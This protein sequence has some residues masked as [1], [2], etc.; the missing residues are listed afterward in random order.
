MNKIINILKKKSIPLD[1]F[2]DISL[3]DKKSGYYMKKNPFGKNGDYITSPLVSNLFGEMIAIWC[4]SFWEYLGKPKKFFLVELGPGNGS[5]CLDLLKIFNNFNSFNNCLH[6]KL[7]EKSNTLKKIQKKKINSKKVKWIKKLSELKNG[8]II[9]I[10]NEFF[11]ALPI[12]QLY[13]NKKSFFERYVALKKDTK[14]IGFVNKK[15]KKKLIKDIKKL[16]LV[17]NGNIIEYPYEALKYLELISK[18]IKKYQGGLL[19]FDYGFIQNKNKNTLQAIK[20]HKYQNIFFD[21]GNADITS[22]INYSLFTKVLKKNNL[23]VKNIVTQSEFLQR[24]GIMERANIVS[25]NISFKAKAD[26]FF[27]LKKLLH[28]KEMGAI[29]KVMFAQEKKLQFNL[30]FK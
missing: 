21:P 17:S 3:Y 6:I 27:R 26:M 16:N 2:I 7:L 14:K 9:F 18:K 4:I 25:K 20:N 22:H 28:H 15:A 24:L 19:I 8:P 11:D 23:N 30:G 10:A 5:L 1:R 29:F 12:K 13:K